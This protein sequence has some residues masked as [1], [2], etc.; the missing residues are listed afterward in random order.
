MHGEIIATGTELITGRIADENAR[1]AARRL[2]EVAL[3][4]SCITVVGDEAPLLRDALARAVKRSRF[5]LIIGG[6]GP[7]DDDLTVAAAAAEL[8]LK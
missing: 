8:K 2:H 5:V 4:I 3:P 6:L 7:T 1:Y